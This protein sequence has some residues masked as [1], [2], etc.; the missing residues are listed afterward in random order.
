[1]KDIE[2]CRK[3]IDEIDR[4]LVSLL[5]RRATL[6]IEIGKQK[7]KSNSCIFV[8]PREIEIFQRLFQL[9]QGPLP[10]EA[11]RSIFREVLSA[12]RFVEKPFAVSFLGPTG[13]FSHMA[14]KEIFG[15]QAEFLPVESIDR[16]FLEVEKGNAEFGVV[17]VENSLEGMV[18][19]TLDLFVDSPLKIYAEKMMPIHHALVSRAD[20]IRRVKTLFSFYQPLA[21]CR[22][23]VDQNLPH[24]KIREVSSSAEAAVQAARNKGSA[25]IAT[26]ESARLYKLKI[27]AGNLEDHPG[28]YTRFLV[29]S[30]FSSVPS[31]QDKTSILFSVP[32]K[33]GSLY[34]SLKPFSKGK[35]NLTKIESRPVKRK[36]WEYI[37]YI[38]F[39]GHLEDPKVSRVM[40]ELKKSTIFIKILGSYPYGL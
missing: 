21:Q 6:A 13:T 12:T 17:P 5:N 3:K 32:H 36:A 31:K 15:S 9:N 19:R 11:V 8:P 23:W 33:A 22:S 27:L 4:Q 1:M 7:S 35:I 20:S 38:D 26:E 40:N 14:S 2:L 10:N 34:A 28:N 30:K 18:S 39:M 16:V 37:F 25:A 29:I 24:V